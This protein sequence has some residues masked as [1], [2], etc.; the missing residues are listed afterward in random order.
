MHSRRPSWRR[1]SWSRLAKKASEI[2]TRSGALNDMTVASSRSMPRS[3]HPLLQERVDIPDLEAM[4]AFGATFASTLRPGDV[5]TLDAPM[6]GGK[7]TLVRAVAT[8][9]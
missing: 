3:Y 7:T 1:Q 5:V 9:L 2:Q 6:G 8:A 4:K